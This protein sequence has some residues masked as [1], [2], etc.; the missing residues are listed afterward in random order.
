M[1]WVE[2]SPGYSICLSLAAADK[3]HPES[4]AASTA[5]AYA[6]FIAFS[7]SHIR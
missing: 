1:S 4:T 5:N 6:L 7:Q 3:E 2:A